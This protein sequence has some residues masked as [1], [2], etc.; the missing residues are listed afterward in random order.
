MNSCSS[1]RRITFDLLT[2]NSDCICCPLKKK[3][4]ISKLAVGTNVGKNTKIEYLFTFRAFSLLENSS[5]LRSYM[6]GE[7]LPKDAQSTVLA[8]FLVYRSIPCLRNAHTQLEGKTNTCCHYWKAP[9]VYTNICMSLL[10]MLFM[11]TQQEEY[12][13][14]GLSAS[15]LCYCFRGKEAFTAILICIYQITFKLKFKVSV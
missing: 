8:C 9:P 14:L 11:Y 4:L 3:A 2:D 1:L 12:Y 5:V 10:S 15:L 6:K 13:S 7:A